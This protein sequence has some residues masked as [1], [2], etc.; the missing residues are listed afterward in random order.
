M[1][2]NALIEILNSNQELLQ[3]LTQSE[4]LQNN[5]VGMLRNV[6]SIIPEDSRDNFYTNLKTLRLNF[7]DETMIEQ[8][9]AGAYSRKNNEISMDKS[10]LSIA[11]KN[12]S[13][14][15]IDFD[16][17][18]L[19][20]MYHE[21]LHMASTTRDE[22]GGVS[23]F[24]DIHKD[25]NG[26]LLYA[27]VLEGM[28]EGFTEYL[29]LLAFDKDNFETSSTYGRQINSVNHLS[30]IV[31]LDTMNKAYFNNGKGMEDI[32][33]ALQEIDGK[34]SH[35]DLYMDIESDYKFQSEE[36]LY[37]P[38]TLANIDRQLLELSGAKMA[39]IQKHNPDLSQEYVKEY[40]EKVS[41]TINS[42]ENLQLI[43]EDASKHTG[44]DDVMTLYTQ[45]STA[46]E[47]RR[48]NEVITR[49]QVTEA[50]QHVKTS[51]IDNNVG[52][53]K[54]AIKEEQQPRVELDS[55]NVEPEL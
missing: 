33:R 40:W 34:P 27:D 46:N 1:N 29:T 11:G 28:T 2:K 14:G 26:E 48:D 32:E 37:D 20:G 3:D 25:E 10:M 22:F 55:Q 54:Q 13:R 12:I 49:E 21:L 42:P 50:A 44:L 35:T 19:M 36:E 39:N 43:G 15:E 17:Q 4:F 18:M 51:E 41:T 7:E 30:M 5:L 38:R 47:E 16:E 31:G 45:F 6:E 53:I 52:E 9:H 23:G 8:Q 24:Q